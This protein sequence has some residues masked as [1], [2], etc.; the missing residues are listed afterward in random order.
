MTLS[1]NIVN[2]RFLYIY[3]ERVKY[4]IKLNIN[5]DYPEKIKVFDVTCNGN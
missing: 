3:Q 1:E 5:N 4:E 2:L